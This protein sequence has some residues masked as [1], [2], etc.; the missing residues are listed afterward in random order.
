M[1]P[2]VLWIVVALVVAAL[3]MLVASLAG[4]AASRSRGAGE[5][6]TDVRSGLRRDRG[7]RGGLLADA[8]KDL[9]EAAEAETGS[10]DELFSLGEPAETDY[11]RP[12]ELVGTFGRATSRALRTAPRP[13]RR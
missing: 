8:R 10:V 7:R 13:G 9:V 11:V 6:L 1:A 5:F 2:V 4:A 3:V 12:G